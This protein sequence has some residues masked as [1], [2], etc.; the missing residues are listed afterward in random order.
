MTMLF[1]LALSPT[2]TAGAI[3]V[4]S[5][6]DVEVGG[7]SLSADIVPGMAVD[8]RDDENAGKGFGNLSIPECAYS[9]FQLSTGDLEDDIPCDYVT[10]SSCVC[11]IRSSGRLDFRNCVGYH[12]GIEGKF[13]VAL[14]EEGLCSLPP[15]SSKIYL[16]LPMLASGF[17]WF[18][19]GVYFYSRWII[20]LHLYKPNDYLMMVCAAT[21]TTASIMMYIIARSSFG[22]DIWNVRTDETAK[23]LKLLYAGE[24][25]YILTITLAKLQILMFYLNTF[26]TTCYAAYFRAA[27]VFV[28]LTN[29]S[30]LIADIL[31]CIP[32]QGNW[33]FVYSEENPYYSAPPETCI[34]VS[35]FILVAGALNIF[36]EF[37]IIGLF[38][39]PI[40]YALPFPTRERRYK[41]AA[42]KRENNLSWDFVPALVWTNVEM[43]I[44]V[45]V[46]CA[47]AIKAWT[48]RNGPDRIVESRSVQEIIGPHGRPAVGRNSQLPRENRGSGVPMSEAG[49]SEAF[50]VVAT[51]STIDDRSPAK[52]QGTV[53]RTRDSDSQSPSPEHANGSS[54]RHFQTSRLPNIETAV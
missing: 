2:S 41:A 5:P 3:A 39:H 29:L 53:E 18:F 46:A 24:P 54:A 43:A 38:I 13:D 26:S 52:G 31:Q 50:T 48:R 27:L 42:I 9:C 34:N 14:L 44:T 51:S 45:I 1:V 15:R 25:I 36:Q 7:G 12:C 40:I 20:T 33:T 17:A 8:M 35:L 47:P 16:W 6:R 49:M 21:F 22:L 32:I 4:A 28:V 11:A 19:L 37:M 23:G 10:N 30:L